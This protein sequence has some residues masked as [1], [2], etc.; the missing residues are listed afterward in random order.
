MNMALRSTLALASLLASQRSAPLAQ[1][2]EPATQQAFSPGEEMVFSVDFLHIPTGEGRVTVGRP[3]GAIWPIVC[4]GRTG[5]LAS[6]LD[7]REYLVSYWDAESGLSRGSDLHAMELGNRH[8]D[9]VRFDRERGKA[10]IRIQRKGRL[11][12]KTFDAPSDIRDIASALMH[13]RVQDL[14]PGGHFEVPVF[15]GRDVFNLIADVQG[16]EPLTT[17][18]GKFDTLRVRVRTAFKGKFSTSRD[19]FIWV[20][21]DRRHI[22]VRLSADFAVGSVVAT[23][24]SYTQGG[25]LTRQ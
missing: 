13:L 11:I 18:A 10:T 12:E 24:S 15:T 4:Q 2:P 7:I 16:R 5:G 17:P 9:S 3:E 25:E 6:L 19:S 22:P 23:I 14:A 20:T 8:I 1:E 21:D